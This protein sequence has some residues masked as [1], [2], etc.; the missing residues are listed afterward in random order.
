MAGWSAFLNPSA[1]LPSPT[2]LGAGKYCQARYKVRLLR[3]VFVGEGYCRVGPGPRDE[4]RIAP[5]LILKD[6]RERMG[7]AEGLPS[8]P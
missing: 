6:A 4:P 5:G 7:G 1:S 8:R 2:V 3:L